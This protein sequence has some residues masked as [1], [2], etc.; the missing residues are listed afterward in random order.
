[1]LRFSLPINKLERGAED[2]L[3]P[4]LGMALRAFVALATN[5]VL[6]LFVVGSMYVVKLISAHFVSQGHGQKLGTWTLNFL[7]EVL[8]ILNVLVVVI[9]AVSGLTTAARIL[10]RHSD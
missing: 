2:W 9:F 5:L 3:G 7:T 1:M 6:C 8:P 10:F 4:R